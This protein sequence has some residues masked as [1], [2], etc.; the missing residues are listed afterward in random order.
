M[1]GWPRPVVYTWVEAASSIHTGAS[2]EGDEGGRG[3]KGK[4][5]RERERE[6][7]RESIYM[8]RGIRGNEE[9]N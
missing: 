1:T 6:R 4:G 5:E 9:D 2:D 8:K 7:E 3:D